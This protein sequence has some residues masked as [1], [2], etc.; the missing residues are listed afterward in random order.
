MTSYILAVYPNVKATDAL[1][2][3]MRMTKGHKGKLFVMHLSFI[4]WGILSCLTFG[5]LAIVYVGP[6]MA[7]TE[8]GFFAELR[9][10]AISSGMIELSELE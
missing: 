5:I 8:A 9:D 7:A 2:L 1:K 10:E 4:G 6:Y 3:S